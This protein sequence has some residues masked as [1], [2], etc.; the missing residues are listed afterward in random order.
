VAL[1]EAAGATV[2]SITWRNDF[3]WARNQVLARCGDAHYIL[4]IDADERLV[5]PDPVRLRRQ[6]ATY[7]S[8]YDAFRLEIRNR[9][10]NEV[11]STFRAKRIVRTTGV[12]FVGALHEQPR[13]L[14]R[15]A[16]WREADL[17]A[18]AIDHL[19]YATTVMTGRD[20][21]ARNLELAR[22]DWRQRGDTASLLHYLRTLAVAGG[23]PA[24]IVGLL[25]AA[26]TD[27]AAAPAPIQ[28]YLLGLRGL[29]ERALGDAPAALRS[30]RAALALVPADE[31]AQGLLADLLLTAGRHRELLTELAA[32]RG[33]ASAEPAFRD[34]VARANRNHAIVQAAA[35]TGDWDAALGALEE[36]PKGFDPWTVLL[37]AAAAEHEVIAAFAAGAAHRGDGTFDAA[38]AYILDDT[39]RRR[40]H[41]AWLGAGGSVDEI[42]ALDDAVAVADAVAA[43]EAL[44]HAYERWPG[45]DAA[46]VYARAAVA[47][48][49]DLAAEVARAGRTEAAGADEHAAAVALGAAA[50]AHER[51]GDHARAKRDAEAAVAIWPA[52]P[53]AVAV[54]GRAFAGTDDAAVVELVEQARRA[55]VD[56]AATRAQLVE[57]AE[58][59]LAARAAG[60]DFLGSVDEALTLFES[61][62]PL[63]WVPLLEA[64]GE[65]VEHQSVLVR[66][67]LVGDGGR[68]VEAA[69]RTLRPE[70][71]AEL[72]AAF[73]MSGGTAPTAVS[74]G[75]TAALM[76]GRADLV[77][78]LIEHHGLLSAEVSAVLA[79][80]L[81]Q[82]GMAA[83]AARLDGSLV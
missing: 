64:A 79:T 27:I 24:E 71:T 47:G 62:Q 49:P 34:R 10:G 56:M 76:R 7:R 77:E 68:F 13:P 73:L 3:A 20:K 31:V 72:C 63:P 52:A 74:T 53:R 6:L 70:T 15:E 41:G 22:A 25:D 11:T 18:C 36:L 14:D 83:A 46:V 45:Q 57:I 17:R 50:A 16:P 33:E 78:L 55:G 59:A 5:C 75:L 61:D 80:K 9:D 2:R 69:A 58:V 66:L 30:A 43:A 21:L 44:Y 23:E 12:Q 60:G 51:R 48:A 19:G 81:R 32:S 39:G 82:R 4:W 42:A 67:A 38:A 65:D 8:T 26:A 29:Q 37:T 1:A 40:A 35:A 28:A 54:L